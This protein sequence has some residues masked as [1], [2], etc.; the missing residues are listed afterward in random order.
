MLTRSPCTTCSFLTLSVLAQVQFLLTQS[1]CSTSISDLLY[2]VFPMVV[3]SFSLA[4]NR[5]IGS[6]WFAALLCNLTGF[7]FNVTLRHV[8]LSIA[9][10]VVVIFIT[11]TSVGNCPLFLVVSD[12]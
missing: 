7:I 3:S 6:G 1:L 10:I 4:N 2:S 9:G 5:Y 11:D 12:Y 8:V